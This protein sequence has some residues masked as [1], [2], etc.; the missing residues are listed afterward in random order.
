MLSFSFGFI[1]PTQ[2]DRDSVWNLREGVSHE[3][4][5]E[6]LVMAHILFERGTQKGIFRNL[7]I[8]LQTILEII[9]FHN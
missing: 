1:L 7:K 2:A 4:Q 6:L 3:N 5:L 9:N 8:D